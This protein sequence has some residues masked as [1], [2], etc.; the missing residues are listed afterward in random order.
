MTEMMRAVEISQP[1]GPE[2]LVPVERPVPEP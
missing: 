1:G 2:V